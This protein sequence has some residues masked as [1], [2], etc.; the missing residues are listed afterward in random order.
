MKKINLWNKLFHRSELEQQKSEYEKCLVLRGLESETLQFVE[1]A[2]DLDELLEAHKK[3]WIRGY[4]N[5]NLGP[6]SYGMFRT[7]KSIPEMLPS[8]VYLGD[9]YGLW[10]FNIPDWNKEKGQT[11]DL[12]DGKTRTCYGIVMNQYRRLLVSNI[13]SIVREC[14]NYIYEYENML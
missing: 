14:K 6:C 8:E 2:K 3:A 7:Q 1:L 12:G 13:K 4:Q 10:T 11:I 9:I 5:A